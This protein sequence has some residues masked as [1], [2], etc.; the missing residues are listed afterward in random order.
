MTTVGSPTPNTTPNMIL[1][2][3]DR[4]EEEEEKLCCAPPELVVAETLLLV[5]VAAAP[6]V[7]LLEGVIVVTPA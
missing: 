2:D 7:G 3:H 6:A 5:A 1:S 4:E